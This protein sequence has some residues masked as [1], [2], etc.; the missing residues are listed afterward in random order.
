MKETGLAFEDIQKYYTEDE[1]VRLTQDLVRIQSHSK[2]PGREAG[3]VEYIRAFL[4]RNGL[5]VKTQ[6]VEDERSNVLGFLRGSGGGRSLMLNGHLDTVPPYEMDFDPFAAEIRDGRILGRGTVDMKGAV[7]CMLMAML[8]LKRSGVRLAGDLVFAGVLGEE[9]RSEGTEALVM[10][11]FRTD[12]AIVG[13]PS[14]FE[15]A[16]GHRGLEWLEIEI[17][18]KAAH[19]GVPHLGINAIV[20]AAKLIQRIQEKIPPMLAN[21]Q[22]EFMGPSVMNFGTISGGTQ[23]STVADRCVIQIDRRYIPG[24]TPESLMKEYTDILDELAA[25]DPAFKATLRRMESGRMKHLSQVPLETPPDAPIV[26]AV[27]SVLKTA[28]GREPGITTRRGW[29]D[30]G[31]LSYFGKIPTV[32]CGPGDIS[33]SHSRHESVPISDLV[34]AVAVYA[35]TALEFCGVA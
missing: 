33:Y 34:M 10:S 29:T 18:G 28:L 11:G 23:P 24:E 27:V 12:G 14:K 20:Q 6:P 15:Y 1:V 9:G 17:T 31:L 25:E 3:V 4:E 16:I 19:G 13:E 22:N 30:A 32:V 2:A 8:A 5:E 21:R 35:S 7:A 26:Q